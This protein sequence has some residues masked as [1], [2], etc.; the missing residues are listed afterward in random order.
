MA[1][2]YLLFNH[3]LT[4]EQI[5]DAYRTLNIDSIEEVP[6]EIKDL[7]ANIPSDLY[8]LKKYLQPVKN[9]IYSL[10]K[11]DYI[12]IHGDFGAVYLTVSWAFKKGVIPIYSTTKR[13]HQETKDKYGNVKMVKVFKHERFREYELDE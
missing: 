6:K 13:I 9:F 8:S 10:N 4:E 11:N 7:W 1:K 3:K 2:L 5:E 12:L